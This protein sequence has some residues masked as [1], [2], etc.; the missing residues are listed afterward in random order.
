VHCNASDPS[1]IP[2]AST[3]PHHEPNQ[4]ITHFDDQT[5]RLWEYQS[6]KYIDPRP[7]IRP[8]AQLLQA[9]QLEEVVQSS[10]A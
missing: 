10:L 6:G 8:K 1:K 9:L 7:G 3:I 5:D 4:F 2:A